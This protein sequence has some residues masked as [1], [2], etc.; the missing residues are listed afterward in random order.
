MKTLT[1]IVFLCFFYGRPALQTDSSR[2]LLWNRKGHIL[3][4][5]IYMA[6][7]PECCGPAGTRGGHCPLF[8]LIIQNSW[9]SI[10]V[11]RTLSKEPSHSTPCH[12]T[13]LSQR[14]CHSMP[15]AILNCFKLQH[16][17]C[18]H[19]PLEPSITAATSILSRIVQESSIHCIKN[20]R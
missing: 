2:L 19:T 6:A 20:C 11:N 14:T 17:M 9:N 13:E 18:A 3:R 1:E 15:F 5:K 8:T 7:L 12:S 4:D 10:K 16:P